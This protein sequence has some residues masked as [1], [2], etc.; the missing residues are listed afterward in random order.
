M[1]LIRRVLRRPTDR[2]AD[3]VVGGLYAQATEDGFVVLKV[4]ALDAIAVH[5]RVYANK[6]DERPDHVDPGKLTL[7]RVDMERLG[8]D[9]DYVP[10][11]FGVGHM[12]ISHRSFGAGKPRLITVVPVTDDELDAY[13]EWSVAGGGVFD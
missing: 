4:L 2:P 12:P 9:P 10:T 1:D 3:A 6:F 11:G 7:G 8:V 13:R 5:I